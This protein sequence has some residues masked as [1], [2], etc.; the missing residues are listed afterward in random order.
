MAERFKVV[1]VDS[2]GSRAS[3]ENE[4][5]ELAEVGAE[6]VGADATTEEEVIQACKEADVILTAGAQITRGVME[7]L[8]RCQAVVRY[9][10]GFDTVDVDAAT[11]N[12]VLVINIP[13]FCTDEVATQ[14]M[15]L[16]LACS[17]H[18]RLAQELL[19]QG[20][21]G[22]WW[23][24]RSPMGSLYGEVL[25]LVGCGNIGR[26]MARRARAFDLK[27]LGFDPYADAALAR[28]SGITLTSLP[29]LLKESDY[30]SLHTPLNKDTRHIIGE[31]EL[32]Q[33]KPTAYL[34]N[35]AR[36][37]V[38]DESALIKALE[39]KRIAGAGLDVFEQ[40]PTD[41]NN[42]LLKMSNVVVTP[43]SAA[44]SD[45]SSLRLATSVGQEA[46]RVLS[47]RWPKNL[48]NKGVTPKVELS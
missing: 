14:A 40:E 29:E 24:S 33:M 34:I 43:H 21:W 4:G 18:L 35:T 42:P 10:V 46:A 44:Y 23:R 39:E 15:T 11:D 27:L 22:E 9:G 17:K 7:A 37:P 36:G 12:G 45:N 28:E 48:V 6:L 38:V 16:L 26:T 30:I 20:R 1:R 5:R 13:D 25:G 41:P 47:G 3:M 2:T 32:A 19:S 8:P 31:A